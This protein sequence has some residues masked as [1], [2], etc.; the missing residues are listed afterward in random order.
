MSRRSLGPAHRGYFYQDIASAYALAKG[1]LKPFREALLDQKLFEGD[2]FDDL[3]LQSSAEGARVQFK[4]GHNEPLEEKDLAGVGLDARIDRLVSS[5]AQ[6]PPE[7]TQFRLCVS[8]T[9]PAEAW[10]SKLLLPSG[11][12]QFFS[13]SASVVFE[14]DAAALW[15]ANGKPLWSALEAVKR[16]EF[17]TFA[18]RFLLELSCPRASLDLGNPGPLENL[19]LK[20]LE[21]DVGVGVYPNETLNLADSA[22]RLILLVQHARAQGVSID[23]AKIIRELRLQT[24]F[25]RIA[26]SFPVVSSLQVATDDL[27]SE[28]R[29]AALKGGVAALVGPPGS[30]KSWSLTRL[31]GDLASESA[32][33]ARHYCYLE[34]GD[35]NVQLRITTRR[36]FSNLLAEIIDQRPTLNE[37]NRPF[38]A[39]GASQLQ[40]VLDTLSQQGDRV[41]LI[42][43]GLDHIARV[44]AEARDLAPGET[45]IIEELGALK[46]PAGV[47][48]IIGSQPG[49]HLGGLPAG[50]ET[51]EVPAWSQAQTN[52]LAG[53]LG[54]VDALTRRSGI[55]TAA[56]LKKL[57][58]TADGN[59]LYATFLCRELVQRLDSDQTLRIEDLFAE[60]PQ[61]DLSAYYAFLLKSVPIGALA[62]AELL[63]LIDF[64]VNVD[65]LCEIFPVIAGLIRAMIATLSPILRNVASQGG[66]RIYHESF[67]RHIVEEMQRRNESLADK[68]APVID[69]L[70]KRGFLE[71]SK[72]YRFLLPCLRRANRID[73]LL[74]LV[75]PDFISLSVARGQ[76]RMAVWSNLQLAIHVAAEQRRWADLA[77][78]AELHRTLHTCFEEKLLDIDLYGRTFAA[79]FGSK[80]LVERLLFDGR[81]THSSKAGLLL[82]SVSDDLGEVPPWEAYLSLPDDSGEDRDAS[83][84]LCRTHGVI[85]TI[86]PEELL[87]RIEDW[88]GDTQIN[89]DNHYFRGVV[90]RLG[91]QQ[92]SGLLAAVVR[93]KAGSDRVRLRLLIELAR[94]LEREGRSVRAKRFAT[95]ILKRCHDPGDALACLRLGADPAAATNVDLTA[96]NTDVLGPIVEHDGT[97]VGKW[98]QAL[99]VLAFTRPQELDRIAQ[100]IQPESWYRYWLL[101]AVEVARLEAEQP[102]APERAERR[103]LDAVG[104]LVKEVHPF[105]G[106]PRACDL[107]R[108]HGEIFDSIETALKSLRTRESWSAA[109]KNLETVTK[110]TTVFLQNSPSGPL[111]REAFCRL[112]L[113][114]MIPGAPL[115]LL[116]EAIEKI[117]LPAH[118]SGYYYESLAEHEMY[119]AQALVRGGRRD[120]ALVAWQRAATYLTGYGF[121]KDA[122]IFELI[123]ALPAL[124]Q[125]DANWAVTAFRRVQRLIRA[126]IAHTDGKTT[127]NAPAHWFDALVKCEPLKATDLLAESLIAHGGQVN[128]R[129]EQGLPEVL[130][131]WRPSG[132]P[133]LIHFLDSTNPPVLVQ[134][135]VETL[136][137][138]KAQYPDAFIKLLPVAL[139][140]AQGDCHE[141]LQDDFDAMLTFVQ[142]EGI[143]VG[144]AKYPIDAEPRQKGADTPG[145]T[146]LRNPFAV[147]VPIFA[148]NTRPSEMLTTFRELRRLDEDSDYE[149]R[150]ANGVGYRL[151][152]LLQE[153][154][155][156]EALTVLQSFASEYY[157]YSE[158]ASALAAVAEGLARHGYVEIAATAFAL[159]YARSR[160]EGGWLSLGG[161]EEQPWLG[162][163]SRLSAHTAQATI[164]REVARI[165][166]TP[167]YVIGIA[168]HLAELSSPWVSGPERLAIWEAAY[169]VISRRLPTSQDNPD[170]FVPIRES[171]AL[172]MDPDDALGFLL[173]ARLSQPELE[174]KKTALAGIS[175]ILAQK[176][177]L[178][179]KGLMKSF[180]QN[181]PDSV[182]VLLLMALWHWEVAPFE[183]SRSLQSQ[184]EILSASSNFSQGQFATRLLARAGLGA[185]RG[186]ARVLLKGAKSTSES[187]IDLVLSVDVADRVDR[188]ASVWPGLRAEVS[189]RF[190]EFWDQSPTN[191]PR[192]A[193]RHEA[194]RSNAQRH[195]PKTFMYW[196][197]SEL[198]DIA[199]ND[200]LSQLEALAWSQGE[201]TQDRMDRVL[202]TVN[203]DA[204]MHRQLWMA[205]GIRP[206]IL[207]PAAAQ[208]GATALQ[209][210]ANEGEFSGWYRLALH[211]RQALM[212]KPTYPTFRGW[213]DLY[214]G[215]LIGGAKGYDGRTLP[216]GLGGRELWDLHPRPRRVFKPVVGRAVVS[217]YV[218]RDRLGLDHVFGFDS[219]IRGLLSLA[220]VG[221][222]L[223]LNDS[224]GRKCVVFRR[225]RVRPL[226]ADIDE[227]MPVLSGCDLLLHPTAY[228]RLEEACGGDMALVT[229]ISETNRR[230]LES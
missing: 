220:P 59:P 152:G 31:S 124:H 68:L 99:G 29:A 47:S 79:L 209:P 40:R 138:L 105:V 151:L 81:V 154:R 104:L 230:D 176:P 63:G 70:R 46:L 76:P 197:E 141:F 203:A 226:G 189:A 77:R 78:F 135:R 168:R 60:F 153:G 52:E 175:M 16:D 51:I 184:L 26:Q 84:E 206:P 98:R 96:A 115:D 50:A 120:E 210:L 140:E 187:D 106:D 49:P 55:V 12:G 224:S 66:V 225:W 95:A 19:L 44:L 67:R 20:T 37:S 128:G 205:R 133:L 218:Q 4:S 144:Q 61:G 2:I 158:K 192:S 132:D 160:G 109:L 32:V 3:S 229:S 91:N 62:V 94:A 10:W 42:V 137:R 148:K 221:N 7:Y 27:Q 85:R 86:P 202:S 80:A 36:T 162:E 69:W 103:A 185:S 134:P 156:R 48:L 177:L 1:L 149:D 136:L 131:R 161:I 110:E 56:V 216:Y 228:A 147:R 118:E 215:V 38:Y 8:R 72:A 88:L 208:E 24:D 125:I 34:P 64:G 183:L 212:D 127:R 90:R 11:R 102:V 114:Q 113:S 204:E 23:P 14:L 87:E 167:S 217:L 188:I 180:S 108:L 159:A 145:S 74:Q 58:D 170:P 101:F 71:D 28:L 129:L 126:V 121:R 17:I 196:W 111:T 83:R 130:T 5:A 164:A 107:Y 211:E 191:K 6:S 143:N 163:A 9:A 172:G 43:D 25:G 182:L 82:C 100:S 119:F 39:A 195:I 65:E 18:S 41:V 142:R 174:R 30:G 54:A 122:T 35:A 146:R 33:V 199:M 181:T 194:A 112:I 150:L 21:E 213:R 13:D 117:V 15:P 73:E 227:E 97:K 178:L 116:C 92:G 53:R 165:L 89:P 207:L 214:A 75:G 223:E 193:S 171:L 201:W 173:L 200:G 123:D 45:D 57:H 155:Q 179:K 222:S 186:Y 166:E 219:E 169:D 139:A 190:N 198:F 157:T 93:T 22:A